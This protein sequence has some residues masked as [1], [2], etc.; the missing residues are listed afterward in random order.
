[1]RMLAS[2][3]RKRSLQL[4]RVK[5]TGLRARRIARKDPQNLRLQ[6]E[7]A[8]GNA[9]PHLA[10]AKRS[11]HRTTGCNVVL[12]KGL[13][14]LTDA[15]NC[16]RRVK[17][18]AVGELF[19]RRGVPGLRPIYQGLTETFLQHA[20]P[21][22]F[23]A[24]ELSSLTALPIVVANDSDNPISFAN[25]QVQAALDFIAVKRSSW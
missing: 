2:I 8:A 15:M 12:H 10:H 14:C 22:K 25:D 21:I 4:V 3:V 9:G 6:E 16:L 7:S 19:V 1:M 17:S 18:E 20:T 11:Q 24:H 23:L 13:E 5:G